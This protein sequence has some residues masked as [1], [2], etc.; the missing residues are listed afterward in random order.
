VA[1]SFGQASKKGIYRVDLLRHSMATDLSKKGILAI[2]LD[3]TPSGWRTIG[4]SVFLEV[5]KACVFLANMHA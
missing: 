2:L 3:V 5:I 4:D 1:R